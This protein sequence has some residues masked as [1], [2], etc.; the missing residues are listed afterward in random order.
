ML[1]WQWLCGL[2]HLFRRAMFLQGW[3]CTAAALWRL[4]GAAWA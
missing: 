4:L 3:W 1:P 2:L